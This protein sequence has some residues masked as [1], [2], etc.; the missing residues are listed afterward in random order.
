MPE[1]NAENFD[2]PAP[3]AYVTLRHPAT[4]ASLSD[5]PMLMDTGADVSL[6][7][8]KSVE[9][10]GIDPIA[11]IAYEIQG[12]D[13]ETKLAQAGQGCSTE[14]TV[15]IG[16]LVWSSLQRTLRFTEG[17]TKTFTLCYFVN[18]MVKNLLGFQTVS[19]NVCSPRL[20]TTLPRK[21]RTKQKLY[22]KGFSIPSKGNT[23]AN[24]L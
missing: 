12:F 22:N 23:L 1:Y 16:V 15:V 4:G 24:Q 6:L 11:D 7:P 10:L 14:I 3:V 20:K 19:I 8:R 5:V 21:T 13:G 9:Q 2:P 17:N 18:V